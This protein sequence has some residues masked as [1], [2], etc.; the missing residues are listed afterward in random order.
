MHSGSRGKKLETFDVVP[1]YRCR[2][3]FLP[4]PRAC[5][6]LLFHPISR[7]FSRLLPRRPPFDQAKSNGTR[8]GVHDSLS[9]GPR[10]QAIYCADWTNA[11]IRSTAN[12]R[13]LAAIT[14]FV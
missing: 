1:C 6:T 9:E 2:I 5:V 8:F 14:K 10:G 4:V 11:M 7:V 13:D 3:D 12:R